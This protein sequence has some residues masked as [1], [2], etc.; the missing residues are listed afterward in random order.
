VD[1]LKSSGFLV[2]GRSR[3]GS[4]FHYA[5]DVDGDEIDEESR[6][7]I[8]WG[9]GTEIIATFPVQGKTAVLL[10]TTG[11]SGKK[12]LE[13]R[14]INT[15]VIRFKSK[16]RQASFRSRKAIADENG[17]WLAYLTDTGDQSME[18]Q[19]FQFVRFEWGEK[20]SLN[21]KNA[22]TKRAVGEIEM[23]RLP[24]QK[25]LVVWLDAGTSDAQ[26]DPKFR[27]FILDAAEKAKTYTLDVT[28]SERIESWNLNR[29]EAGIVLAYITGDTLL[30]ENAS[31]QVVRLGNGGDI[32]EKNEFAITN[33]HVGDPLLVPGV[34]GIYLVLSKWLDRESTVNVYKITSS[35]LV[36]MGYYGIFKEGTYLQQA[37]FS[38]YSRNLFLVTQS[39]SGYTRKY[40]LC[41]L[42]PS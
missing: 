23:V 2:S 16:E 5:V 22:A 38:P 25:A 7:P 14:D 8:T 24:N 19:P 39:P 36:N 26:K 27:Y 17:F 40:T 12:R 35:D 33:E 21:I 3:N 4:L 30:W 28:I 32:I 18:D 42:D 11:P 6:T 29:N 15:N 9:F 1:H 37:F 20:G 34:S 41:A 13:I 31:L 10:E